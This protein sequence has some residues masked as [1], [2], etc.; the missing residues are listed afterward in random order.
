MQNRTKLKHRRWMN[1]DIQSRRNCLLIDIQIEDIC[2][3]TNQNDLVQ[4]ISQLWWHKI[5]IK[6][7]IKIFVLLFIIRPSALWGKTTVGKSSKKYWFYSAIGCFGTFSEEKFYYS[8]SG[9]LYRFILFV[10]VQ[11]EQHSE[12]VYCLCYW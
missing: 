7:A 4:N 6:K 10:C 3:S 12:N 11:F 2:P 8:L 5:I 9:I 1:A